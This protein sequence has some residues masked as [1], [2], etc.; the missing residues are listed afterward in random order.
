MPQALRVEPGES[1]DQFIVSGRGS[2]HIS[3]LIENM[4][5]EGYEFAVGAPTVRSRFR[6][7]LSVLYT[8]TAPFKSHTCCTG[9]A[10]PLEAQRRLLPTVMLMIRVQHRGDTL[11]CLT[12]A[13]VPH[14]QV[15]TKEIDG[16]KCEPFEEAL[17]EVPEEHMGPAM[18]LLGQ[19]KGQML[20]MAAS[21]GEG[22]TQRLKYRIPTR[23]RPPPLKHSKLGC[24]KQSK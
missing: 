5:R 16:K 14:L 11:P 1:A 18:D 12:F 7:V 4:R 19:R 17:L 8:D 2:L 24:L 15:I 3:I 6:A 9:L 23:G 10:H 21:T 22:A 20:D 13:P